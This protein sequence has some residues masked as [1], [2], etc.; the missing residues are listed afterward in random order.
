LS[1]VQSKLTYLESEHGVS[2]RRVQELELELDQCKKDVARERT[3]VLQME[4]ED[5][6]RQHAATIRAHTDRKGKGKAAPL[7][8]TPEDRTRYREAVEEKK[9]AV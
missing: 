9:G 2:R 6:E 4:M 7:S 1:I 3:R 5:V 8:P